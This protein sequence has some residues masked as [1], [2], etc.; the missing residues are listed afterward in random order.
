MSRDLLCATGSLYFPRANIPRGE[1]KMSDS[2]REVVEVAI[3]V[4]F[5]SSHYELVLLSTKTSK[6]TV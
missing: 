4:M 3:S 1:S 5:L 2:K 6:N